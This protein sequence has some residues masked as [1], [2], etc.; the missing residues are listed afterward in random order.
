MK[1]P[2]EHTSEETMT[3]VEDG[4]I[5]NRKT[6][7]K[8]TKKELYNSLRNIK[9]TE[10]V[11]KTIIEDEYPDGSIKTKSSEK[12]TVV[13]ENLHMSEEK[14]LSTI[15]ILDQKIPKTFAINE[16]LEGLISQG[17]PEISEKCI[18]EEIEDN[19]FKIVRTIK[20]E[21]ART[22]FADFQNITKKV[23]TITT[24]TTM[25][26]YPDG[27]SR[28]TTDTKVI[29]S[30]F[31]PTDNVT[32]R[33]E[34][35]KCDDLLK[36]D[37]SKHEKIISNRMTMVENGTDS[38]VYLN[39]HS[40]S[41]EFELEY[42]SEGM[43]IPEKT[44]PTD[45]S[46]SK[47]L[48]LGKDSKQEEYV[49]S[50][51]KILSQKENKGEEVV[52]SKSTKESFVDL[53]G[54]KDTYS[55]IYQS[56]AAKLI[57]E[58][59]KLLAEER[60][61]IS[62]M[63]FN[64]KTTKDVNIHDFDDK[65]SSISTID[66][67]IID[68]DS[69]THTLL[70][71]SSSED[72][73]KE[74]SLEEK[75]S[76]ESTEKSDKKSLVD[77]IL[78]SQE[79]DQRSTSGEFSSYTDSLQSTSKQPISFANIKQDTCIDTNTEASE[80]RSI[81][82]DKTGS[83]VDIQT[84]ELS[85]KGQESAVTSLIENINK[86]FTDETVQQGI[87]TEDL[88][89]ISTHSRFDRVST[90]PTAPV[91]PL[92]N[93][94]S[95]FQDIKVSDGIQSEVKYDKLEGAEETITKIVHVGED[96]LTQKISTSTEKVPK[97]LKNDKEEYDSD[98]DIL[99]LMQTMGKI[100]TETDTTTKIIKEGENVVTQTITTVTTKEII[101]RE[102]GTPQNV[103]TTIET[104]TLS[105]SS[106]GS[107]TSTTDTQTLLSECSS[108]LRSTSQMDLYD[109][110]RKFDKFENGDDKSDSESM[111][112][113]YESSTGQLHDHQS[114]MESKGPMRESVLKSEYI[115]E[116]DETDSNVEDTVIDTDISKKVI[117]ENGIDVI[118]T[119]ATTTK[120]EIIRIDNNKK[121]IKT[122]I[123]TNTTR[124][125]PGGAK[126]VQKTVGVKTEEVTIDSSSNL[127]K[128]LCNLTV[129]GEPE[130]N[131]STK[132]ETITC[133]DIVITRT[134]STKTITI[135]YIDKKNILR[136]IK[137]I[138]MVTTTDEY[139]DGSTQT[140][141][142]TST[143]LADIQAEDV[144]EPSELSNYSILEDKSVNVNRQEKD[145]IINGKSVTQI[146]TTTT[147]KEILSTK[148]KS[149]K[150]VKTT[151]ETV[152]E[153]KLPDGITEITKDI[154]ISISDYNNKFEQ[155]IPD[156]FILVGE[157]QE[158]TKTET[159]TI[160]EFGLPIKRKTTTT[161]IKQY[162]HNIDKK[163][164][165]LK[166]TTKI[167]TEDEYPDGTVTMKTNEKVSITE[168]DLE[169]SDISNDGTLYKES[170]SNTN[171]IDSLLNGLLPIGNPE[172][173]E[174]REKKEVLENDLLIQR[175]IVTKTNTTNYSD[176][177]GV[178]SRRKIVKT[179]TT[180]DQYPDGSSRTTVDIST[181]L[182]EIDS[183]E[184]LH[185]DSLFKSSNNDDKS[186]NVETKLKTVC[187]DGKEVQ[188]E[189]TTITT[190]EILPSTE[191]TKNKIRT[192]VE[193]ITKSILPNGVVEVAKDVK[194]SI[195]DFGDESFEELLKNYN[196]I[197]KPYIDTKSYLEQIEENGIPL[198]R[199]TT[200]TTTKQEYE[201]TLY[202]SRKV[203]NIVQ[204]SIEDELPDG[205]I[206]TKNLE[207]ISIEDIVSEKL[208][209][210]SEAESP[211][212][213]TEDTEIVED[214]N[215]ESDIK[216]EILQR[217]S[218][219]IKRTIT[220][221][222]KRDTL[223]SRDKDIKRV[224]TTVETI[225]VDEYPDG[226]VETTK[227][228]K[229]TIS[230]FQKT[231]ES[232][233]EAALNGFIS[234]GKVKNSVDKKTN[235]I[236][237]ESNEK[238]TQTIT[239][240]I[241]KEE[242]KNNE[243]K[244]GA[245]KT[246]TETITENSH[247]NGTVETTK[248][249][250]TQITYLPPG[251]GLDDCSPDELEKL[252]EQPNT[253]EKKTK[254]ED[255]ALEPKIEH[256]LYEK[257]KKQRS[258]VGEITTDTETFTKVIKEGNNEITQTITVVTTKEVISPEKIKVTVETTTVSK[259]N[260]GV[261]KTT[262]STK[263]TISE[264]KEEYEEIIDTGD[265]E[266]SFSKYSS[267]TLDLRSS[268]AASDDLEHPGISTPPSDISSRGSRAATHLWGT[269]SSGIYYSDDDGQ[270]SPSSTKSQIAHSPRSN[271]SFELDPKITQHQEIYHDMATEKPEFDSTAAYKDISSSDYLRHIGESDS[272]TSSYSEG[273]SEVQ[274]ADKHVN[275]TAEETLSKDKSKSD[276]DKHRVV[277]S[278]D[279][280]LKEAD[281]QFEK[282]IE[283]YKKV[284][285]PD[286]ISSIT[287][288]YELD[289]QSHSSKS[290]H[291]P[292]MEE[293]TITLKELKSEAKK[294]PETSSLL[295]SGSESK[296]ETQSSK[297]K[298]PI[299]SWGK[300]LGLPSPIQ[301]PTQ[302]DGKSTPKKQGP[303][304]SVQM[305]N[306]INQEKSKEAKNRASESPSKKKSPSPVYM[307]LTYVPHHGNSYYSAV[308]FFK[309]VRARYYVFSGTEPSK[310]IY[311]ALLDAKK[312]WEDKDLEVTIIP[313]Y[314]TDVLGYWVT[315]NE[316]ALEKYKIDLS[317]SASRCTIN[318]QD[319]ETS[320]AAY[321][322]EF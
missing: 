200:I 254:V 48:F 84:K 199:K 142:D 119:T 68:R 206:V 277:S 256:H 300:P 1:S 229:I 45:N 295:T 308:E 301:P 163:L 177:H 145:T 212:S 221:K 140:K 52:D 57:K 205:E 126:A 54:V 15:E 249:V 312:T 3:V 128:L 155:E 182:S 102:D 310:E 293:S 227:D 94:P 72:V 311:N 146:I 257:P 80:N 129:Y 160:I 274:I 49:D 170:Y 21:T 230:E 211:E 150:K 289:Q 118:E 10:T 74:V 69:I 38:T 263:T 63:N 136:K 168:D 317:P 90:P 117:K 18:V 253:Q 203:K 143:S 115:K 196:E 262:K 36:Q 7:I 165:R 251:S 46:E 9:R 202:K 162:Y 66:S 137:T 92:P 285:G 30:D 265:S 268:S 316:E 78:S 282:A 81:S 207:E 109:K 186:V 209:E 127:D 35:D 153:S 154:K 134:I 197:G 258:P 156:G 322:L 239:T 41:H 240:Y 223:A 252:A 60:S 4:F 187:R 232:D 101:S 39:G 296:S 141:V 275:K 70:Q 299:E 179:I 24:I 12:L 269:E 283:E 8:T 147:T 217:G 303:T 166:T 213:G 244:E 29:V 88:E 2:E 259:S 152:T 250:R 321:R 195:A 120:K 315:E 135:K 71:C 173:S 267:K 87:K 234:T 43:F 319:H 291:L 184:I 106:D 241:T 246:V 237:S 210:K 313:T 148:D 132:T 242:Y 169:F 226:S 219:T 297:E 82:M 228:V 83:K 67:G 23:K 273:K 133:D 161:I 33:T 95:S 27:S 11:V 75:Y 236:L 306:K 55:D 204:T 151:V 247:D 261:T 104:T 91:S 243:T 34:D 175:T 214:T 105:K 287:A 157:P 158:D 198:K 40:K 47:L 103:K 270:G 116:D 19:N 171:K 288:K 56:P 284:S 194:V 73:S 149:K 183:K 139:P 76:F 98:S 302:A 26:L 17:E 307:E 193:T 180:T 65:F 31:E 130:E 266:K 86:A 216:N 309:R 58:T 14:L 304:S 305:K 16:V 53:S 28:S 50:K 125:F 174:T 225:T 220:T 61:H 176:I 191:E 99:S 32:E 264:F 131:V 62:N 85:K 188:Q 181:S 100:K 245:V 172:E 276:T 218:T 320:C 260:D 138:T 107:I 97:P 110:D 185:K 114:F 238:I 164:K 222:T 280:F 192:T 22:L 208:Q 178:L 235:I 201:N 124:E 290:H 64:T 314:D 5:I 6:I 286:V 281:E 113:T 44:S 108:S 96:V 13:E 123:E 224:R 159:E 51:R 79:V 279:T 144:I 271:V 189:V 318:L 37:S 190:K 215:E 294:S 77:Q 272:C 93:I 278:D 25:D 233:L 255:L 89:S 121:I 167:V 111:C 42:D 298:D 20:T 248:D 292:T 231:S 112:Q 59:E 122:T